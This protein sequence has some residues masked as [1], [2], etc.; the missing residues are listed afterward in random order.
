[1]YS[2]RRTFTLL[3]IGLPAFMSLP[4]HGAG[5]YRE[6]IVISDDDDAALVED[7]LTRYLVFSYTLMCIPD[8]A[9]FQAR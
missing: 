7:E 2:F 3:F 4:L 6:P 5:S 8:D 1:M 9:H